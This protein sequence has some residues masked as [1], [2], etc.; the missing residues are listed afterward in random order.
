MGF[1]ADQSSNACKQLAIS[2]LGLVGKRHAD[3]IDRMQS[4]SL[5][6]VVDP[7]EA[8]KAEAA[9]RKAP[10]FADMETM[11]AS[12]KPDGVVLST[13]TP[14]HA[15]QGKQCVAAGVPALIEKPISDDLDAALDLVDEAEAAN[16]PILVGH[17]RRHN[18][19]I[20][21]AK[22][23]IA[24]GHIGDVRAV[25]ATCWFYKPDTY[26]DEAPWRKKPGAGPISVNLVHDVDL[27]RHLCG[28]VVGVQAQAEPS[29]RGFDNEDVAAALI[30]FENGAIGTITVSDSI[31]APWSWELTSAEYPVYPVTSE[32]AYQIG[33]SNGSLSIPDLRLWTHTGDRDWWTP[34]S[35]SSMP[36]EAADPLLN[37]MEHFVSVIKGEDAP[38]V[39]GR[40]G[41]RTL[42]VV[43]AIQRS[44]RSGATIRFDQN[45]LASDSIHDGHSEHL[46]PAH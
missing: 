34:I 17:H 37:Q 4:A 41:Y 26:F 43:D 2:G 31:V 40:E 24:E 21:K 16:V 28:E 7:T 44:A 13:P 30:T 3:V 6:A 14:L 10:W 32:S 19:L 23:M 8:G 46:N 25:Q 18:P 9:R 1:P 20:R 11:L 39:S 5:C 27:I 15:G 22:A 45:R 38:L 29:R 33:G 36:R 12:A 42:A 35:A